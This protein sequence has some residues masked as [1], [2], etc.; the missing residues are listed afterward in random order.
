MVKPSCFSAAVAVAT[1]SLATTGIEAYRPE[2]SHQPPTPSPTPSTTISAT[3]A[4]R[5][6]NNQRCRNGSR[7]PAYRPPSWRCTTSVRE[8]RPSWS[9]GPDG[10]T[11]DGPVPDGP[12]PNALAA[13]P[14]PDRPGSK[15]PVARPFEGG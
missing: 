13:A 8:L 3:I 15:G 6:L 9:G 14:V 7:A 2:V 1:E 10:Q 4:S 12:A 5:G 11:P